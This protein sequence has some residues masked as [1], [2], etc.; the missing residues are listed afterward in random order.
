MLKRMATKLTAHMGL[1]H[2]KTPLNHENVVPLPTPASSVHGVYPSAYD[3]RGS[4]STERTSTSVDEFA[5]DISRPRAPRERR[6]I[7]PKGT[8]RLSDFIIQRTLGTGSFGRV[9]LGSSLGCVASTR[10]LTH[11]IMQYAASTIRASTQSRC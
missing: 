3:Y 1:H 11:L 2:Q 8:Y 6:P 7:R 10:G 4:I 5:M 9:H